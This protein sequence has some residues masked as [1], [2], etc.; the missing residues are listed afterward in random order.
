[1]LS[2]VP[3]FRGPPGCYS[4]PV[5]CSFLFSLHA[6][7]LSRPIPD[8][9]IWSFQRRRRRHHL[10]VAIFLQL[11]RRRTNTVVQFNVSPC[12][13]PV[14][15]LGLVSFPRRSKT[16]VILLRLP[17]RFFT[18]RR[19][20]LIRAF[21]GFPGRIRVVGGLGRGSVR[22]GSRPHLPHSIVHL[23]WKIRQLR[24]GCIRLR[25]RLQ[26]LPVIRLVDSATRGCGCLIAW[27]RMV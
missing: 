18:G 1:M 8:E 27:Q 16:A 22:N 5:Q 19:I 3:L 12:E 26:L 21:L 14:R 11:C 15:M 2:L 6:W 17:V 9:T 24:V 4:C 7:W 25:G 20:A 13:S 23:H 10:I